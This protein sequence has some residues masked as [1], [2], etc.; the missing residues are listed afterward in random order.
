MKKVLLIL[1]IYTVVVFAACIICSCVI[2]VP[3]LLGVDVSGY[4]FLRGMKYFFIFLPSVF[5]SSFA[6]ACSVQ[7]QKCGTGSRQR[8][9]SA[10]IVR[11]RNCIIFS[12]ILILVLELAKE[13]F[14]PQINS[15]LA[16][17][18]KAPLELREILDTAEDFIAEKKYALAIQ[19]G[20]MAV[21]ISGGDKAAAGVLKRAEDLYDVEK[22]FEESE[23]IVPLK[24]E[25]KPH[26]TENKGYTPYE[27][28]QKS[29][30][31][32]GK[33]EWFEAHY[34]AN[35]AV[36]GCDGTDT[37]FSQAVSAANEAWNELQQPK[38]FSNEAERNYYLK[39]KE[40]YIALNYGDSL[41]AYYIFKNLLSCT[42]VNVTPDVNEFFELAKEDLEGSY[43]FFD[44]TED[45]N[46]LANQH[47]I[48]FTLENIEGG[49]SV[50]Y[51]K[52]SMD[53]NKAGGLVRYVEGFTV[54][55]FDKNGKLNYSFSVPFGKITAVKTSNFSEEDTLT[56]GIDKSWKYIPQVLLQSVDRNTEGLI[57]KPEYVFA[58]DYENR[59]SVCTGLILL[60][61]SF[62]DFSVIS[63]ASCGAENMSFVSLFSFLN[64]KWNFGYADEL[65]NQCFLCRAM[66]RLYILIL[67]K[68]FASFG[69]NYRIEDKNAHFKF[70]WL[71]VLPFFNMIVYVVLELCNYIYEIINYVLVGTCGSL[72]LIVAIV[73]YTSI[74]IFDSIMFVSRKE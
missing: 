12:L 48:Y 31:A 8:F 21:E 55:N 27:L 42:D 18:E 2:D 53:I 68:F 69:W 59:E 72:A 61:M 33:G 26:Q 66:Y 4:K 6:V 5:L 14:L 56:L 1:G 50:Y 51:I 39:K 29:K 15:S 41:K 74:F 60:P 32:A 65:F 47:N 11:F 28:I 38:A 64:K 43:F 23:N 22:H 30:A 45:M 19:Y 7:W 71:L 16:K 67:L 9:S 36:E 58:D 35:L 17:K 49:K 54:V 52:R 34:W 63:E 46:E 25:L 70:L 24:A 57:S 40:G 73:L 13:I 37:N 3:H 20:Q 62:D 10:M 44:E